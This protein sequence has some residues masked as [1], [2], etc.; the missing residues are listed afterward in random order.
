MANAWDVRT[1]WRARRLAAEFGLHE[2]EVR[3]IPTQIK[4]PCG[5]NTRASSLSVLVCMRG[6][7]I[8]PLVLIWKGKF[9]VT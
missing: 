7:P 9:V 8:A 5:I 1:A 3:P 2:H 6:L 4:I